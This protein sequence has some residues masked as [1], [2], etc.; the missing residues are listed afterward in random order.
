ME[1]HSL[2]CH[3][4][5][6]AK[7]VE[8]VEVR[9]ARSLSGH[10]A[11]T[12]VAISKL[13]SIRIPAPPAAQPCRADDLWKTTCFEAFACCQDGTGYYEFNFA[14]SGDWA[15]YGFA[16]RRAGMADAPIDPPSIAVTCDPHRLEVAVAADLGELAGLSQ[17]ASWTLSLTAVIEENGGAKSYWAL[18]HPPGEPDFHDPACFTALLPAPD[19]P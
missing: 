15:A 14:P 18:A 12:Y 19:Y 16:S 10:L 9:F 4:D 17:H 7:S 3:P 5:T 1:T 2:V 6:P 13:G 8:A 11:V